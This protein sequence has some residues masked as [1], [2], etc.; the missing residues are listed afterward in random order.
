MEG[1]ASV[2]Y[3][4]DVTAERMWAY[5]RSDSLAQN[6]DEF[7]EESLPDQPR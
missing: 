1:A 2:V 7:A 5:L 6:A 3:L 4:D